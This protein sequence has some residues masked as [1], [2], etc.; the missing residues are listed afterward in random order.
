MV[1]GGRALGRPSGD[2]DAAPLNGISALIKGTLESPI[3]LLPHEH[4][5]R[6]H[7]L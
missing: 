3:I 1:S 5:A 7:H 4:N 6:R 2:E